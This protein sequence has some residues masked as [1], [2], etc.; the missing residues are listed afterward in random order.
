MKFFLCFQGTALSIA[1]SKN[2]KDIVRT[3]LQNPNINVNMIL[4]NIYKF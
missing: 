2:H 1:V 4:V 3:L